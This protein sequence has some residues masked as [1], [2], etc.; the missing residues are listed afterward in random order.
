[1]SQKVNILG[2]GTVSEE[3]NI[4]LKNSA[5]TQ[6][7][8]KGRYKNYLRFIVP[9]NSKLKK[10]TIDEKEQKIIDA[11]TDPAIYEKKNFATPSALEVYKETQAQKDI[12]GFLV[13]V[14]TQALKTIKVEYDLDKKIDLT[15]ASS[16]SLKFFKQPGI[17]F[18][19]FEFSLSYPEEITAVNLSKD[20]KQGLG[21]VTYS[22]QITRD[23]DIKVDFSPK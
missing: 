4:A 15:K 17:D 5:E 16:Y 20:L 6:I 10:I 14:D 2:D 21:S 3:I 11:I 12:Y 9:I 19:P 23:V 18:I 13:N 22:S 1:L 7:G 8:E